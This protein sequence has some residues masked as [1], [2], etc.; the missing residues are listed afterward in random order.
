M[1]HVER[2]LQEAIKVI[3][4]IDQNKIEGIVKS[5]IELRQREGRLF[6]LGVGGGAAN[7]SHAVNDLRK[8]CGI[9][10]YTPTDNVSELTA[11]TNDSG[12]ES[13]F[14]DWLRGSKLT[15]EDGIFILSVGG[16]NLEKNISV[17]LV[18]ALNYARE[19]GA[20]IFGIIGRDGGFTAKVADACVIV[21]TVNPEA[22]TSHTESFQNLLLHLIVS[23]PDL[24]ISEMKWESVSKGKR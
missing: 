14:V 20:K 4:K 17:N 18:H 12:W 16:G 7:A 21:P 5:L 6:F 15:A 19:I 10:A 9:E 11:R 3:E 2:Y 13:V 8:I 1:D 22:I 23:H 24:K